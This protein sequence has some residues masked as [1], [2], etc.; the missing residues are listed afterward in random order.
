VSEMRE[1]V[2]CCW[3][4]FWT[5]SQRSPSSSRNVTPLAA[6]AVPE[7]QA[8]HSAVNRRQR[9]RTPQQSSHELLKK[10][11]LKTEDKLA[12]DVVWAAGRFSEQMTSLYSQMPAGLR[13]DRG[14]RQICVPSEHSDAVTAAFAAL[15]GD[16]VVFQHVKSLRLSG[17]VPEDHLSRLEGKLAPR[18]VTVT[19]GT[20]L[21][22]LL[23]AMP[24]LAGTVED[25]GTDT[26]SFPG[27]TILKKF[28]QLQRLRVKEDW[29]SSRM[30]SGPVMAALRE[31]N[32]TH[33]AYDHPK[34]SLKGAERIAK[35]VSGKNRLM[36]CLQI[37]SIRKEADSDEMFPAQRFMETAASF[38]AHIHN[39][40]RITAP[41][42]AQLKKLGQP[43]RFCGII[44]TA[45]SYGSAH[46]ENPHDM[47]RHEWGRSPGWDRHLGTDHILAVRSAG[48][49][50][51]EDIRPLVSTIG[52]Q[53][54][55]GYLTPRTFAQKRLLP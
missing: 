21:V 53:T 40:S 54:L 17:P 25:I 26:G 22:C 24:S 38:Y 15:D 16:S 1:T 42:A 29:D 11:L 55:G 47:A 49:V 14:D 9:R 43:A 7:G 32:L 44:K 36:R 33:F 48:D 2:G 34:L 4:A 10:D 50:R 12:E 41:T 30:P 45:E 52:Q 51:M 28:P 13:N 31:T 8:M 23:A 37:C 35:A 46:F 39:W 5:W 18:A 3:S 27:V 19:G 20:D 6:A